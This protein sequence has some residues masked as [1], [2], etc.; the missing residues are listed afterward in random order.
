M[1]RSI[2]DYSPKIILKLLL[3]L[4]LMQLIYKYIYINLSHVMK[5]NYILVK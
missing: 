5:F 4:Y 3:C 2:L 1:E